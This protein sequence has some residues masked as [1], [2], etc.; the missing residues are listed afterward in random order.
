M[1][2]ADNM[3][4]KILAL[5]FVAVM[6]LPLSA[7][8]S[9]N[10]WEI[11]T[12]NADVPVT[13]I[14]TGGYEGPSLSD[15]VNEGLAEAKDSGLSMDTDYSDIFGS[16]SNN[17]NSSD[18]QK[19]TASGGPDKGTDSDSQ[20]EE[21]S[22][23]RENIQK[24]LAELVY[25]GNAYIKINKN[26]P[27]FTEEEKENTETFVYYSDLD[28]LGRTGYAYASL[29][30]SLMPEDGEERG[31]I[32]SIKPS[33]WVQAKYEGI[34]NGDWLYNRCHLI[35]WALTGENA[36][37]KNL[38]TGTRYFNIEGMLTFEMK[39]LGYL[40]E[41][42]ENHLLYRATPVYDENGLLAKG[43]LL[44]AYSVED[45]GELSFCVYLF[46]IQPGIDLC[47]QTGES[48]AANK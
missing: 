30:E 1:R 28:T 17:G 41:N 48:K 20:K 26:V 40:D 14:D 42:P 39:A 5:L 12:E 15:Y 46:N 43:L 27:Y 8:E 9:Y 34:G 35:A 18:I 13:Y 19:E 47:Y 3:K 11:R 31:D 23:D 10:E 16:P 21:T 44:E 38:M 33:G 2:K 32:S 45:S 36:N 29:N 24:N 22:S 25:E 37:E 7:C 4:N 6:A